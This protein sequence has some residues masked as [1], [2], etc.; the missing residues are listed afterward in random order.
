MAYIKLASEL[1]SWFN[2]NNYRIDKNK[3]KA[4][5]FLEQ[6]IYR[7]TFIDLFQNPE[8]L[9]PIQ[10][11]AKTYPNSSMHEFGSIPYILIDQL[12]CQKRRI[13][14]PDSRSSSQFEKIVN[15]AYSKLQVDPLLLSGFGDLQHDYEFAW[16]YCIRRLLSDYR[17]YELSPVKDISIYK[18][19]EKFT[20]LPEDVAQYLKA[21]FSGF[22]PSRVSNEVQNYSEQLEQDSFL[23]ELEPENDS[24]PEMSGICWD[25]INSLSADDYSKLES[26]CQANFLDFER[27][28]QQM[29]P[30]YIQPMISIDLS[31]S[32]TVIKE[33][34]S[35][36]LI[37]I[38][39]NIH[40]TTSDDGLDT[41][42]SVT[43]TGETLLYKAYT[44]QLLAY[45]DLMLWGSMTNN[46]I[47]QSVI[48]HALFPKGSYDGEFV[49]KIIK[50]FVEKL[51]DPSSKEVSELFSLKNME[52]F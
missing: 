24:S 31:C 46:K 11:D 48:A 16:I 50:P 15:Y 6:I 14:D 1:P 26:T 37:K 34:F 44:Y 4:E 2:I 3:M 27:D 23:D 9:V 17:R 20:M 12:T 32:D 38:R 7:K 40:N 47:K 28:Q 45:I 41:H 21:E 5:L 13:F 8:F 36:W 49:R 35:Q 30:Y 52:E 51:F 22:H 42:Y 33:Q 18:L 25:Y 39:K 43:R 19:G 10:I 29:H